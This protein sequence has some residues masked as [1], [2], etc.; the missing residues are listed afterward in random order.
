M[1]SGFR[2][3][4]GG[5]DDSCWML[6]NAAALRPSAPVRCSSALPYRSGAAR[7][8]AILHRIITTIQPGLGRRG[9]VMY[10]QLYTPGPAG[11]TKTAVC[12]RLPGWMVGETPPL[13]ARLGTLADWGWGW[14]RGGSVRQG[15]PPKIKPHEPP[16]IPA[17]GGS[18]TASGPAGS[19]E[20][21]RDMTTGACAK[22]DIILVRV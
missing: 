22:G 16:A 4:D 1:V 6:A 20:T 17:V 11:Y 15:Q 2:R 12:N 5:R 3:N 19:T 8:S 9:A 10:T 14:Q 13:A 21:A 18:A 7:Q